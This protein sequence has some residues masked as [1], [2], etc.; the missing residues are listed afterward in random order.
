MCKTS[1]LRPGVVWFGEALP[2][3]VISSVEEYI[4][5][6]ERIELILV[7]GTSASVYPA[8]AY[9]D[10]AREKGARVAVINT[11]ADLPARGLSSQDWFFR[12]DASKILP[13]LLSDA[14]GDTLQG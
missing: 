6:S 11:E 13:E 3:D 4:K 12:G 1:L 10:R 8:A 2:N 9:V 14:I 5:K 7:I